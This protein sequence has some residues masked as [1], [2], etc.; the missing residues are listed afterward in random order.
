MTLHK[1]SCRPP[2]TAR[3]KRNGTARTSGQPRA[4]P[5]STVSVAFES[6]ALI[7]VAQPFTKGVSGPQGTESNKEFADIAIRERVLRLKAE[8]GFI[9]PPRL[10]AE[11][12]ITKPN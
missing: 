11:F 2:V 12:L 9:L 6:L 7:A 10:A 1:K 3:R 4:N 5:A 8:H